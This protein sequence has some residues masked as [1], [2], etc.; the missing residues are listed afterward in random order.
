[1]TSPHSLQIYHTTNFLTDIS[2]KY[3]CFQVCNK[4]FIKNNVKLKAF[5]GKKVKGFIVFTCKSPKSPVRNLN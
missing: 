3:I 5:W 4:A 2:N 1:M